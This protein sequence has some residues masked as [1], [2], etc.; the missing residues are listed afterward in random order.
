[1]TNYMKQLAY[2]HELLKN[3]EDNRAILEA[4]RNLLIV[5]RRNCFGSLLEER[6]AYVI[7]LIELIEGE[8]AC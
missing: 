8:L 3:K 1:M 6:R 7:V 2:I 5:D 4:L